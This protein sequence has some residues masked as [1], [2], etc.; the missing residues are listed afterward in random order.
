V[1]EEAERRVTLYYDHAGIQ[2]HLGDCREILPGLRADVVVT[3]PPYRIHAGE[4]GGAFGGRSHLVET[5]GFTDGGC[6]HSFLEGFSDWFCFASLS[7]VPGLLARA[8]VE[9]VTLL[10]W[11]KPNPVPTCNGK[12]LPDVEYVV[13][14]RSRGRLFGTM[15]DKSCYEVRPCGQKETHHPNEKPIG[16]VARLIRLGSREGETVMDPFMG[17]G[18]TLVAAKLEGRRAIG[19]EIEERY[20]EIAAKRLAQEV[21]D[22]G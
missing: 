22:F 9:R 21:F 15:R 1:E 14:R 11:C 10:T 8:G 12:Y 19:I 16:F 4:G 7:Q 5:G 17:S 3:D 13:H 6:D 18:T 20:C 2:I